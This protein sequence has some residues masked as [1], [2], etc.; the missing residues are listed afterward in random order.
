MLTP[1]EDYRKGMLPLV[2]P[3]TLLERHLGRSPVPDRVHAQVYLN[4]YPK[5]LLLRNHV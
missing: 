5:E 2:A 1:I 4:P 3:V